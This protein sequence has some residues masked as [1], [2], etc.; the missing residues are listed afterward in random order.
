M[1][2]G[3]RR[4]FSET[5]DAFSLR[6]VLMS[7]YAP[8][9]TWDWKGLRVDLERAMHAVENGEG[10]S[11]SAA[12]ADVSALPALATAMERMVLD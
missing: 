11:S 4:L 8:Q 9:Q 2:L 1:G 6:F 10:C 12:S 3:V 7:I 5:G